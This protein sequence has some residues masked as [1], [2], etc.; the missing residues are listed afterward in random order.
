MNRACGKR[1]AARS[2]GAWEIASQLLHAIG[3][4]G[5]ASVRFYQRNDSNAAT[6]D[7]PTG[8]AELSLKAKTDPPG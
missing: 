4:G 6:L 3:N 1:T 2:V 8:P 5:E 7:L